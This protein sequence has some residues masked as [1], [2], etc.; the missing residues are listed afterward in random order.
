MSL[1]GSMDS[2]GFR[3]KARGSAMAVNHGL[4]AVVNGLQ[5]LR[6]IDIG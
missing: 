4:K 2:S 6:L 3:A 1:S 5:Y